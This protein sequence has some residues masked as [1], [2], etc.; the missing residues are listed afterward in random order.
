MR[1][2]FINIGKKPIN[3]RL[4]LKNVDLRVQDFLNVVE[5]LLA[6]HYNCQLN[7]QFAQTTG[8]VALYYLIGKKQKKSY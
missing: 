1:I 6:D 4:T 2:F 7:T 3:F 8:L 5:Y